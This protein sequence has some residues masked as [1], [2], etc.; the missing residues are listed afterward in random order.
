M[1]LISWELLVQI[2]NYSTEQLALLQIYI[3]VME[4]SLVWLVRGIVHLGV[5]ERTGQGLLESF[6]SQSVPHQLPP[7]SF[8]F[9]GLMPHSFFQAR[10]SLCPSSH[11]RVHQPLSLGLHSLF[12]CML[13]SVHGLHFLAL[14]HCPH[15][16]PFH[17]AQRISPYHGRGSVHASNLPLPSYAK[18]LA[19]ISFI[20]PMGLGWHGRQGA[21]LTTHRLQV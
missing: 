6:H 18:G 5:S 17:R 12:C 19:W 3:R 1:T 2:W 9:R 16:H 4:M 21:R 20:D 8:L 14:P 13:R 15:S 11:T 10:S 7:I